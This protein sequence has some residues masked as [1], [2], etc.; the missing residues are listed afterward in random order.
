MRF[1][2]PIGLEAFVA[3]D[4]TGRERVGFGR[5]G[6][7]RSQF[8]RGFVTNRDAL[9]NRRSV[10]RLKPQRMEDAQLLGENS[11]SRAGEAFAVFYSRHERRIVTYFLRRTGR[12]EVAADLAAET[13]ARALE[14]R[15][16]FDATRGPAIAWLFGIAANVL[17]E[18][19]RVGRVE[20]A[21]RDRLRLEP[22]VLDDAMLTAVA[23]LADGSELLGGLPPAEAEAIGARVLDERGY[24][25]I[26]AQVGCSEAV[27]RQRVSRGLARLRTTLNVNGV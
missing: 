8:F 21:A 22:V 15:R 6:S 7:A 4:W 24:P 26:A 14:S 11:P 12:A 20:R 1:T 13:F 9:R 25:E 16:R 10:K 19:V 17:S 3:P 2:F 18:S 23:A 27:V 5:A